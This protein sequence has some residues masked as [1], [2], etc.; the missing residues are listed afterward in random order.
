[1]DDSDLIKNELSKVIKGKIRDDKISL[2]EASTDASIFEVEPTLVVEA[3]DA[4]DIK[5]LV[6]KVSEFKNQGYEIALTARSGGTCMSGGSLTDSIV[7]KVNHLNKIGEVDVPNRLL[8]TQPGAFYRDFEAKTMAK[9][10]LLPSYTASKNICT[11]GG[12]VANNSS[13][14]LTLTYGSTKKFVN[15]LKV[16]L[17]DSNEY[18]FAPL[19]GKALADKMNSRSFDGKL[20]KRV[21]ELINRNKKLIKEAEPHVSKNSSGYF[22]WDVL[23]IYE[24]KGIFDITRLFSGSQGTLGIISEIEF[25]LEPIYKFKK[26]LAITLPSYEI[27]PDVVTAVLSHHPYC[28]ESFD[29]HTFNLAVKYMT[30]DSKRVI[31]HSGA[32]ITLIAE[33]AANKEEEASATANSALK[34]LQ[35]LFSRTGME[36][37]VV[38][39][40]EAEK[41]YWNIRRGSFSLLRDH[42]EENHRAVPFIDDFVVRPENLH[43]FFP[44][45]RDLLKEYNLIY[46]IAGHIGNGNFHL[47]PL[48]DMTNPSERTKILEI[49]RRVFELVFKYDG[50]MTG[51]HNDGIIRTPFVDL[52]FGPKMLEIFQEVKDIFDPL[53]IFNPGKKVGGT[54]EYAMKHIST[55]NYSIHL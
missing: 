6:K 2:K 32:L 25:K 35:K 1:M 38:N 33:F 3:D 39:E 10:L 48:V 5:N 34:D 7:L 18:F 27:L 54:L 30:E 44:E 4:E 28:F 40:D 36:A 20:Y 47:I 53:N 9:N 52:M 8:K 49:S 51:E 22:L 43:K 14:E 50:S 26:L 19:S 24:Q 37:V 23:N 11:V 13:G 16:I 29:D 15:S 41:S 46:T 42:A 45:L 17:S 55:T 21:F 31:T 12:M